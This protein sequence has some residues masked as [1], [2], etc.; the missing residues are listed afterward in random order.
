MIKKFLIFLIICLSLIKLPYTSYADIVPY[1]PKILY[2]PR[3]NWIYPLELYFK[4]YVK[5][6]S[7][8]G[9]EIN[10]GKL[11]GT[12][13]GFI[14]DI[15][16]DD[17]KVGQMCVNKLYG[18]FSAGYVFNR[19]GNIEKNKSKVVFTNNIDDAENI[20]YKNRKYNKLY[21]IITYTAENYCFINL[22][23]SDGVT[24][25]MRFNVY[26]SIFDLVGAV[27]IVEISLR[28]PSIAKII[29]KKKKFQ[30]GQKTE[31]LDRTKIDWIIIGDNFSK[32]E[33]YLKDAVY[34]YEKAL[35]LDREDSIIERRIAE[36]SVQ[37]AR[38][39]EKEGFHDEALIYWRKV[40]R[41][42][43]E[44]EKEFIL[45]YESMFSMA[46]NSLAN[47]QYL[48]PIKYLE[49]LDRTKEI[50]DAACN[51][52]YL[53]SLEM[54]KIGDIEE[55]HK[56]YEIAY[57]ISTRNYFV[58]EKLIKYYIKKND[59][60]KAEDIVNTV[61]RIAGD[62][63]SRQ[64]LD[65]VSDYITFKKEHIFPSNMLLKNMSGET[66]PLSKIPEPIIVIY[67]WKLSGTNNIGLSYL[68]KINE[69]YKNK[70]L[71]VIAIN[72][73]IPFSFNTNIDEEKIKKEAV[74]DYLKQFNKISFE[75][76]FP[77]PNLAHLFESE[78]IPITLI[79]TK[80]GSVLY[81]KENSFENDEVDKIINLFFNES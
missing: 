9:I 52:Y 11:H 68:D 69:K 74:K 54:E 62:K 77:G 8:T 19:K 43:K 67:I 73:D 10:I 33:D 44:Y 55:A 1:D 24:I 16:T 35:E 66:Y 25:G 23:A 21:G 51:A 31:N 6:I 57:K 80:N 42:N 28:E 7:E 3:S 41:G 20:F 64:Y 29:K 14:Y 48:L 27:E 78:K 76:A 65:Q 72:M 37:I 58:G 63:S 32:N 59:L 79:V 13:I 75:I 22:N 61:M 38:G 36:I 26:D 45:L 70:S 53:L 47:K 34:A 12:E 5:N 2:L 50:E 30:V 46:L 17:K 39:L 15:Y 18:D 56:Y 4:G 40:L 81:F 49:C 71:K 60:G